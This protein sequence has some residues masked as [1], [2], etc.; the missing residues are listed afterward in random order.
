MARALAPS[1]A[2]FLAQWDAANRQRRR[3]LLDSFVAEN[4]GLALP[5]LEERYGAFLSLLQTRI[6]SSLRLSYSS[7]FAVRQ[8]LR[9]LRILIA[10]AAG[11]RLAEELVEAGSVPVLLEMIRAP[12]L[13]VGER[14][15]AADTLLAL[16]RWNRRYME[17]VVQGDGIALLCELAAADDAGEALETVRTFLL[18]LGAQSARAEAEV[19][20]QALVLLRLRVAGRC[21]RMASQVLLEL[22]RGGGGVRPDAH[23]VEAAAALFHE[24]DLRLHH[25]A[26]H[27]LQHLSLV[28]G[29]V[30]ALVSC[31]AKLLRDAGAGEVRAGSRTSGQAHD[32]PGSSGRASAN[33]E[34]DQE[35][36]E[37]GSKGAATVNRG[38]ARGRRGS[39]VSAL[40]PP[41]A[42]AAR[43]IAELAP[44]SPEF[45]ARISA[46]GVVRPLLEMLG[47]AMHFDSQHCASAALSQLQ[48]LHVGVRDELRALFGD[49]L[50]A[51]FL[52]AAAT[53][54]QHED[55]A[56]EIA[57]RV[58]AADSA[59]PAS[60]NSP[61]SPIVPQQPTAGL[62]PTP[63]LSTVNDTES[64][65]R[66]EQSK[67]V[68]ES[69]ERAASQRA[70]RLQRV[71]EKVAEEKSE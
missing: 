27:L 51:R 35:E 18:A 2:A 15:A 41:A 52:A 46:E 25:E 3:R 5:Q 61:P 45:C 49:A 21:K 67:E 22:L 64:V 8:Q 56:Q 11:G 40:C 24:N 68:R 17:E 69:E 7:R 1:A 38:T 4:E 54:H 63:Q 71:D 50:L 37:A 58:R 65:A 26:F 57:A 33:D 28:H 20:E 34:A 10:A 44:Q 12:A 31:L 13:C 55:L 29:L 30:D 60:A 47:N 66:S 53:L 14:G 62:P 70:P 6:L 43:L 36:G 19:H 23:Y 59:L 32:M 9:A 16:S 39:T 48:R 42:C